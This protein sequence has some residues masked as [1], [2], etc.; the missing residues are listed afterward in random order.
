[1]PAT[2]T[3]PR[4]T[5][6]TTPTGA[7]IAGLSRSCSPRTIRVVRAWPGRSSAQTGRHDLAE[8]HEH[9][10]AGSGR[11]RQRR[12]A[13]LPVPL[14]RQRRQRRGHR[15]SAGS[16]STPWDR[17]AARRGGR[18]R[19][20]QAGRHPLQGQR[21]DQRCGAGDDHHRHARRPD[22]QAA[23]QPLRQLER[24]ACAVL[25]AT[26][27]LHACAGLVPDRGAGHRLGRQ[28]PGHGRS[29]LAARGAHGSTGGHSSPG[30]PP[31]LPDTTQPTSSPGP[32]GPV[33]GLLGTSAA[34]SLRHY[35]WKAG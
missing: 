8:R 26:F 10:R 31:G 20:R 2:S 28:S 4:R 19:C 21:R 11:P 3:L 14:L 1:M 25:L 35:S 27:H 15:D 17:P 22:H 18:R 16:V 7:G 30:W 34:S 32:G 29:Q 23:G 13:Q 6:W 12:P 24:L 33:D 5:P 9:R